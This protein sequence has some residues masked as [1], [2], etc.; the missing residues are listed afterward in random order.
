MNKTGIFGFIFAIAGASSWATTE[1]L[2]VVN[3]DEL[4]EVNIVAI[5]L[6]M[7][8]SYKAGILE[9]GKTFPQQ[10]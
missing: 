2:S 3:P 7:L 9:G 1:R 6:A 10:R 4:L 8:C 5:L